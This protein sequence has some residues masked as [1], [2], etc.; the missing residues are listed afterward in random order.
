MSRY[1]ADT[2]VSSERSRASSLY[3]HLKGRTGDA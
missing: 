1:A 2:S 3:D